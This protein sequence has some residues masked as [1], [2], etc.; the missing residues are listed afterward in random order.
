M[1]DYLVRISHLKQQLIALGYHPFQIN[2]IIM[3]SVATNKLDTI[4]LEQGRQ[5]ITALEEYIEFARRSRDIR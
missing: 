2:E 4:T 5:L 3:D 1:G